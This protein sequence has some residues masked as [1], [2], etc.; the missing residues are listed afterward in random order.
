MRGN[1]KV[2]LVPLHYINTPLEGQSANCRHRL[3][4][5]PT[6]LCQS[7]PIGLTVAQI[8]TSVRKPLIGRARQL[9][10]LV[11]LPPLLRPVSTLFLLFLEQ[12]K[13]IYN[14]SLN[15]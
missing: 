9:R 5:K 3:Y 7:S 2:G 8:P 4:Q 10:H 14:L 12:K 11:H 13:L 6:S 15:A 1:M